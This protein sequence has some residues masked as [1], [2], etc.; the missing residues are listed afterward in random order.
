MPGVEWVHWPHSRRH[1]STDSPAQHRKHIQVAAWNTKH[2]KSAS[3]SRRLSS[4]Y[5]TI[6][7]ISMHLTSSTSYPLPKC[8]VLYCSWQLSWK[9]VI[10]AWNNTRPAI[11]GHDR[12]YPLRCPV[13]D[14]SQIWMIEE[15]DVSKRHQQP[16]Q[17]GPRDTFQSG[18]C[19]HL[20]FQWLLVF[21]IFFL[22]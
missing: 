4:E 17:T 21:L 13:C 7:H 11:L 10:W 16:L 22:L 9:C 3:C 18:I 15:V 2:R 19:L 20:A 14:I 6:H 12:G 5:R 8:K 1:N